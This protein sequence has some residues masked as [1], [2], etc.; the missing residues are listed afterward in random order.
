MGGVGELGELLCGGFEVCWF[1]CL[2]FF[3]GRLSWLFGGLVFFLFGVMG[4]AVARKMVVEVISARGLMPKDGQGSS[5]AYCVVRV[6]T[7]GAHFIWLSGLFALAPHLLQRRTCFGFSSFV[8]SKLRSIHWR[9]SFSFVGKKEIVASLFGKNTNFDG[10][11]E[12]ENGITK[13]SAEPKEE[14]KKKTK[15]SKRI[16]FFWDCCFVVSLLQWTMF[17]AAGL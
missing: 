10:E 16:F 5:N 13:K 11:R 8:V 12:R 2:Y 9:I 6:Q 1:V 15:K 14:E 3:F 7:W 17:V 4:P